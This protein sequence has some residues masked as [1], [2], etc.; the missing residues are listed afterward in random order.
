MFAEELSGN[1][2]R[3]KQDEARNRRRQV[4]QQQQRRAVTAA[5]IVS[6]APAA[7]STTSD[8]PSAAATVGNNGDTVT[9]STPVAVSAAAPLPVSPALFSGPLA[10]N[11]APSSSATTT[12]GASS[13]S[14]VAQALEQRRIRT[15]QRLQTAS[16]VCIQSW[17]RAVLSNHALLHEERQSFDKRMGDLITLGTILKTAKKTTYVPPPATTS[18]LS[19][20]LLFIVQ[21][22]FR[23]KSTK[24]GSKKSI[25]IKDAN[26]L[27]SLL[28]H[29]L[30][31]GILS[32]DDQ[33]DPLLPWLHSVEGKFRLEKLLRFSVLCF[34]SCPGMTTIHKSVDA[35]IRALIVGAKARPVIAQ[36]CQKFLLHATSPLE[37]NEKVDG[38]VPEKSL[39]LIWRLRTLL[40]YGTGAKGEP[41]PSN[42]EK[43]RESCISKQDRDRAN[44]MLLLVLDAIQSFPILR[45][46]LQSRFVAEILTVP[47]FTWKVTISN[48]LVEPKGS[49]GDT[50]DSPF[51]TFLK[52]FVETRE[53]ALS[54]GNLKSTLFTEDV[55]LSKC[56]A[57]NVLCLLANLAQMGRLCPS[58][59]GSDPTKLNYKA[60]ALFFNLLASLIDLVPLGTFTARRS[61]V[62]WVTHG[63]HHSPIV[64]ST[65]VLDQCKILLV[66]SYVRELFSSA[67]N[68]TALNTEH[69]ITSKNDKDLKLEQDM[70]AVGSTSAANLAAKEARIDRDRS[71][72]KSSKW[73]KKL[74]KT[75]TSLLSGDNSSSNSSSLQLS[76]SGIAKGGGSL[77]NTS[78][79]SRQLAHSGA[80]HDTHTKKAF[81]SRKESDESTKAN[82]DGVPYSPQF[83]IALCRAYGTI[84]SRWGGGGKQ[85]IVKRVDNSANKNERSKEAESSEASTTVEPCVLSLLN[86]ICFAT[87]IVKTLGAI[88]QSDRKVVADLYDIIDSERSPM[89][90]RSMQIRPEYGRSDG[91]N[92]GATVLFMFVTCLSHVLIITDDIEIHDMDRPLPPHQLRRII[93]LL[94]RLLYRA[95]CVD[96]VHASS[97]VSRSISNSNYFGLSLISSSS[98]TMRD[99]YDR[100]SR[101]PLCTPKMWLIEDLLEKDLKRC[102]RYDQF[103]SLLSTPVLRVC[104]FLVSFK[105]RLRLFERIVT[106]NRIEI[107]G[108]NQLQNLKPGKI[109]HITRGRILED[110]LLHLNHLGRNLRQRLVVQYLNE[111]GAREAGVDVGGLFKEFWTD[112]SNMAFDPNFALF[113]ATEGAGNCMYP[114]PSSL[115]A[116]GSDSIVLF[117]FLGRILG[118][119]LYEGITIQPQFAHFFLSFLRGDYNFLHMLPDLSTMDPQLYNNLM[120]LKTYEGDAA[121]LCLTFTV[122]NDDFGRNDEIELIP[123]GANIEVTN[124]NKQRYIGLMAKYHVCDKVKQ[125]SQAFTRGLWEVIDRSWLQLF[126]EP[127][128]Q[129]LISGASDGKIDVADMKAYAKYSGGFSGLDKHVMRFW[130]V[131]SSM[132]SKQQADLLKFVTSCERPPPLGFSCMNPPFTIQRVGVMRDGDKLPSASTC[133]NTLK[134]PT[135]SSEK[136]MRERLIYS[137]ESGAGF[138]LS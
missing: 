137:I 56:P 71:F 77:V 125:Q 118:K 129:V 30:L 131:F 14:A 49:T 66:D 43:M 112:L 60:G 47:L 41:I 115:Q 110:G 51:I 99:L 80:S 19:L 59:N 68:D 24:D 83:L 37:V 113:R 122:A 58:I 69:V 8:T 34:V 7:G 31:P 87:N 90:I 108:S 1:A 133:F 22:P 10:S 55:P 107:Q 124:S 102:K 26:R 42:A 73:A 35:L 114:N 101:R 79:M 40:L 6:N 95:C 48:L 121:D 70:A 103:A 25:D 5:A 134:L 78:S 29:V 62:E 116:H 117:E 82:M 109:V 138:E 84:L 89:P 106:T 96:D 111:A 76:S 127:E 15:L 93:L 130:K 20:Q 13:S 4:K 88:I 23:N 136:V 57:P 21:P 44:I 53:E 91:G 104:P 28:R 45:T 50:T 100:S 92:Q 132:T 18:M 33:L 39:D 11:N 75:M 36:H 2:S 65:V 63:A 128:L 85:D 120:F 74:S 86:V 126:N 32:D 46:Q 64:L 3:K 81:L 72:W 94:K 97:G 119:A 38:I 135:Y 105:R 98:R 27:E 123:N 67:I 61:A 54:T 9:S 16:A 52:A 17:F 12:G